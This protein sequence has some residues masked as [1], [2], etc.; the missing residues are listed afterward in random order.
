VRN[1]EHTKA[2]APEPE[3]RHGTQLRH[4]SRFP[5]ITSGTIAETA[6]GYVLEPG[7]GSSGPM[8]G[9]SSKDLGERV[10]SDR[11]RRERLR[12]RERCP[13]GPGS[14]PGKTPGGR[15]A[16]Q[17]V[18]WLADRSRNRSRV[19]PVPE[20]NGSRNLHHHLGR[21]SLPHGKACNA[22]AWSNRV[23]GRTPDQQR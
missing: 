8:P 3:F 23:P 2:S 15:H 16:V 9:E 13:C 20:P 22:W 21:F 4:K 14:N 12:R 17:K 18:R 1:G 6:S 7:W 5:R 10:N 19:F 11:V